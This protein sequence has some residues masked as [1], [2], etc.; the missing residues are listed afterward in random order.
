MKILVMGGN[1]MAGHMIRDILAEYGHQVWWSVRPPAPEH[2][3]ALGLDTCDA[4]AVQRGLDQVQPDV[5]INAI[6][7]LNQQAERHPQ[8]AQRINGCLPHQLAHWAHNNGARLIHISTDCVFSGKRGG[9]GIADPPDGSSIYAVTKQLG[10]QVADR[11]L[12]IRTSIVGPEQKDGIGL[13]HWFMKQTGTIQGYRRVRW[14]G[15]TTLQLARTI[16]ALIDQPRR[17]GLLQLAA[18]EVLSKHRLLL[19]F[20]DIFQRDDIA[21]QPSDHPVSD[22]SLLPFPDAG[23]VPPYRTMMMELRKWMCRH[24]DIYSHYPIPWEEGESDGKR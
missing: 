5:I 22:K 18:T 10:E 6:G 8:Q 14:N 24:R 7:I 21:I 23:P 11:Q 12:V 4:D 19:L 20:Q 17:T 1:G 13:F 9:Y 15:V 3:R 2:P 16:A